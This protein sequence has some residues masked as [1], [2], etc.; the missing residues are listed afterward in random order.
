MRPRTAEQYRYLL[1]RFIAPLLG[2]IPLGRLGTAQIREWRAGLLAE[3]VS[4]SMTAKSYRLLRAVLNLMTAVNED[5]I[6]PRNPCRIV[7]AGTEKPPERPVLTVRQVFALAE[8]VSH[9][10]RAL[11][12]LTTFASLRYGEVTALE[13]CD[14]DMTGRTVRVRQAFTEQVGKGLVLGPPKSR[15]GR[16]IV[17]IPPVIIPAVAAHLEQYVAPTASARVYTGPNGAPI[18]RGNFNKLLKW[19]EAVAAVGAPGLH[20]HDL[21]HTGNTLA[22]ASGA[23]T[24]DLMARMGHDSMNAASIYQHASSAADRAIADALS[25]WVTAEQGVTQGDEDAG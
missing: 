12:V 24:R 7:G 6:L 23:S 21:R 15:A 25:V 16:R 17:A 5:H 13:R 20:F 14:L 10:Y 11:I 9:R 3:G 4:E 1:R 19:P 2:G 18:R 22:A 8:L